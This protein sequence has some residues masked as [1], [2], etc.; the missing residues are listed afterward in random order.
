MKIKTEEKVL[1]FI[2]EYNLI[3]KNEKITVALSGGADSVCLLMILFNLKKKLDISLDAV[4]I[5]HCLR[6]EESDRDEE[7][8]REICRKYNINLEVFNVDVRKRMKDSGEGTEE[9]ARKCRYE[10][11]AKYSKTATAHNAC[12]NL[13][14]SVYNFMRGSGLKGIA[15]IPPKREGKFIRPL[16][17]LTRDEILEYLAESGETYVTDSTNLTDEYSRNRIRHHLVPLMKEWNPSLE[18]TSVTNLETLRTE[19][20]FVEQT[21][22]E[23]Y[24]K[25]FC[26]NKLTN[27]AGYHSAIRQR[28][29]VKFLSDNGFSYDFRRIRE[30]EEILLKNGRYNISGNSYIVGKNGDLLIEIIDKNAENEH[31]DICVDLKIGD[32]VIYFGKILKVWKYQDENIVKSVGVNKKSTNYILD[33]DKIK[34]SL[35]LRNRRYG[36][37]IMPSGRD[38]HVSVKKWLQ[39]NVSKEERPYMH[40]IED[41]EGLVFAETIGIAGRVEVDEKTETVLIIEIE[42]LRNNQDRS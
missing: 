23:T 29:I 6:G 5:N 27:L 42:K 24:K 35:K 11:F 8:C 16:L 39:S 25:C 33:Y 12:D 38:F 2:R 18:H 37:K 7:F 10:I 30:I 40:Y 19:L 9:A 26:D 31:N 1:K 4:H 34:G 15:G 13:E 17:V 3:E 36:D 21:A 41:D 28:C 20:D 22:L 14:T 32:N